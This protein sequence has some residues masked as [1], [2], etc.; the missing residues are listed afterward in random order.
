MACSHYDL[1]EFILACHRV[2]AHGLLRCSSGNLSWR[3]P[4]HKVAISARGSW[5]GELEKDQIAIC[6]ID[7]GELLEGVPPSVESGMHLGVYAART[8]AQCV[9]H[10]Q[11]PCATTLCCRGPEEIDFFVIPEVPYYI[12][13]IGIVEYITPGTPELARAVAQKI[14]GHDLLLLKNH[15]QVVMGKDFDDTIQKAAFFEL[16]CEVILRGGREVHPL[17]PADQEALKNVS[18]GKTE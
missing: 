2:A 10:F 16:A 17:S 7:D 5:L 8:D 4:D 15:G 1:D 13:P 6:R 9:L 12:G 3:L 18:Y 11:S 14:K